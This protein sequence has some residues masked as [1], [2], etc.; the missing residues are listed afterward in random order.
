MGGL[1]PPGNPCG[2]GPDACHAEGRN[3]RPRRRGQAAGGGTMPS[4]DAGSVSRW[5]VELKAGEHAAAQPLW[6]RYFAR[7]VELARRRL[8]ASRRPG[9]DEDEEDAALSAFN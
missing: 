9:A 4:R 6:E 7:L 5:I 3:S 8:Q 1:C 2:S